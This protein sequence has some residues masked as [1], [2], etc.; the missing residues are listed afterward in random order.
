MEQGRPL[1]MSDLGA[2]TCAALGML[3]DALDRQA[4]GWD[5]YARQ[6]AEFHLRNARRA[7]AAAGA[8]LVAQIDPD[9]T[10]APY[11]VPAATS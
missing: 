3:Q 4:R 7:G 1:A 9:F 10:L 2:A 8:G 11:A 6:A 5:R